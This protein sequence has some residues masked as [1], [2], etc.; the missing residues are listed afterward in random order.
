MAASSASH[1]RRRVSTSVS[2][3]GWRSKVERLITL[4]TSAVAVCCSSDSAQLACALQL[5]EQADVLDRDDG[6]VG[7]GLSA[8]RSA[9]GERP[10]LLAVDD[11]DADQ[12]V[13]PQHRDGE[14]GAEAAESTAATTTGSRSR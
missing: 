12:L 14:D 1:S 11:D 2:S 9:V 6:L 3:T 8:A 13:V 5:L 4:S 7:E 10:H